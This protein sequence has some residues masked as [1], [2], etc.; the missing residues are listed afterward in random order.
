MLHSRNPLIAAS[1]ASGRWLAG[2][3][4]PSPG[5]LTGVVSPMPGTP[6]RG[7]VWVWL[8]ALPVLVSLVGCG[9][10]NPSAAREVQPGPDLG[11]ASVAAD[12]TAPA[13]PAASDPAAI[14]S[15]SPAGGDGS[16]QQSGVATAPGG[17]GSQASPRAGATPGGGGAAPPSGTGTTSGGYPFAPPAAASGP[18]PSTHMV[19][20]DVT[21][22][23]GQP[24]VE[25]FT[26]TAPGSVSL[27]AF[28]EANSSFAISSLRACV[29][30]AGQSPCTPASFSPP[31]YWAITSTDL[32][33]HS[34]FEVHILATASGSPSALAGFDVGWNGP[35]RA[36]LANLNLAGGCSGA[37]G[38]QTE[39]P[40]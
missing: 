29:Q 10:P 20:G 14:S 33:Q 40:A 25:R 7:R 37:T 19:V 24:I 26:V 18:V 23:G 4:R 39:A 21:F 8:V 6:R 34:G 16:A 38:Y 11:G 17:G 1:L 13:K 31:V 15:A 27:N 3:H 9:T 36:S 32:A 2:H 35:Q 30:Y 5:R 12:A 22:V 28:L